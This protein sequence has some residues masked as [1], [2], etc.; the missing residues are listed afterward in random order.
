[1]RVLPLGLGFS[2][3]S[4]GGYLSSEQ[5][6][7]ALTRPAARAARAAAR[8]CSSGWRRWRPSLRPST[9]TTWSPSARRAS[10][11]PPASGARPCQAPAA[12]SAHMAAAARAAPRQPVRAVRTRAARLCCL[13]ALLQ[14]D[15][16]GG[17]GSA[18]MLNFT[19]AEKVCGRVGRMGPI[20]GGLSQVAYYRVHASRCDICIC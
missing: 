6:A 20:T 7:R 9:P 16:I 15:R 2:A 1:M 19:L 14:F 5:L 8:R 10:T 12:A 3:S 17:P 4:R 11:P 18:L 13:C